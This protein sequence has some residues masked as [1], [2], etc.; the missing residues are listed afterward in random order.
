MWK[1]W[2]LE[3][4]GHYTPETL[5]EYVQPFT[6]LIKSE[7]YEEADFT[8][9]V[10]AGDAVYNDIK[11]STNKKTG[12]S[13][14]IAEDASGNRYLVIMQE[15][16]AKDPLI[17]YTRTGGL[18]QALGEYTSFTV[19]VDLALPSEGASTINGQFRMRGKAGSS[20]TLALFSVNGGAV[21]I[22]GSVK[23]GAL[24]TSFQTLTVTAD[25][26]TGTITARLGDGEVKMT[27]FAPPSASSATTTAEWLDT[28][29]NYIFNFWIIK[30]TSGAERGLLMDN[31]KIEVV[32]PEEAE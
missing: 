8:S 25:F 32:V 5:P 14:T 2:W 6:P 24:T 7:D 13:F 16:E 29:T 18:A 1:T 12:C 26:A 27:T 19:T 4:Y 30:N 15:G 28:I 10:D 20:D 3:R 21:A 9:S 17:N 23:V 11:Y 31:L 22:P